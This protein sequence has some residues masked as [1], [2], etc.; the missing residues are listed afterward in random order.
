LHLD[1]QRPF[2]VWHVVLCVVQCVV[3]QQL[4]ELAELGL[5]EEP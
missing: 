3:L 5:W 1:V 2:V 4:C